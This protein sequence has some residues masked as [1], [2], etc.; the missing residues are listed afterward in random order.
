MRWPALLFLFATCLPVAGGG[1]PNVVLIL[2]DDQGYGD[3]AA[4]GN[5]VV[6]TPS[7]D[8][9]H[10]ESVRL[11]DYHVDP[12]C[13]P[14][15]AALLTGRYSTRTGVW[16]TINGRSLLSPD[17]YTL[18]ELFRDHG[19]RTGLFG[20]WHLGDNAPLR[21]RD[22]GFEHAVW[23]PGGAVDQGANWLGTDCFGDTYR[24]NDRWQAFEGYHTDVWFAQAMAF[25]EAGQQAGGNPFFVYLPATAAHDPWNVAEKYARPYREAG[26]PPEIARF[27][28]MLSNIDENVGRLRAWL[29]DRGLAENTILIF[30]TDNGT[31][32][33]WSAD[34]ADHSFFNAGMR[35][36]KGSEYDGGHRVP[37]FIHWPAGGVGTGR[38]VDTLAGH[39][40]L[41]PTLID[42]CGLPPIDPAR[43]SRG[44]LDGRSLAADIL[45]RDGGS[46]PTGVRFVHS[47]RISE[48]V[49]W[50]ACAVMTERWRLVNGAE[51]YD[52]KTDPGQQTD[53]AT[54]HPDVVSQLRN[55]YEAWW[56]S[57]EP[58]FAEPV[59]FDLGGAENPT[60]LMSHDWFMPGTRH[61]AWHHRHVLENA[62][63]N[64][65]FMVRI[66]QAG[67][68][69]ITPLR[70][71]E[72]LDRPVEPW[73]GRITIDCG[74]TVHEAELATGA[75]TPA[76]ASE[77]S[78]PAG[79]ATLTATL[80]RGD[81]AAFGAYYVK[82]ERLD[83]EKD[84]PG[85]PR[86]Q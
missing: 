52:I 45:G 71:P 75:G 11:T 18:A 5:P 31:A 41:L 24:V 59:R 2:I 84:G 27:Y 49:K 78:L 76:V 63:I 37:L 51:L 40:D 55:D 54:A 47:Q 8:R 20:K 85:S 13:S 19:Y 73:T 83:D 3:M 23:S 80:T 74:G 10:A 43:L 16:H 29:A 81:G 70:W 65:S 46:G 67:R 6:R 14:T 30:T 25:I 86:P 82:V 36:W 42:L 28:G 61:S 21:P 38:D 64:G 12:T 26:V 22:Q 39:I 66:V 79:P 60:T 44:P 34:A 72:Y 17:E 9:L 32:T 69:R 1:R 53:L 77:V 15:R 33:G 62:L 4:L 68:Y 57:L 48:P 7:L 56:A 50:R 35:G 58:V